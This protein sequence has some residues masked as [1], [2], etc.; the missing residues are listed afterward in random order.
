M[1]HK[2]Q[3]K[4]QRG[5]RKAGP[6]CVFSCKAHLEASCWFWGWGRGWVVGEGIIVHCNM[7][8]SKDTTKI[9][10]SQQL[11]FQRFLIKDSTKFS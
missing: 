2:S 6:L 7:M 11:S 9:Y 4:F 1:Q 3:F 10:L 5:G 8:S